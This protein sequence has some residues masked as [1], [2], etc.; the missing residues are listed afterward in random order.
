[1]FF[2]STATQ[3]FKKLAALRDKNARN[4]DVLMQR[5]AYE[6]EA[7][8][9]NGIMALYYQYQIEQ[10]NADFFQ[11]KAG[12][13]SLN[14]STNALESLHALLECRNNETLAAILQEDKYD[15]LLKAFIN[16]PEKQESQYIIALMKQLFADERVISELSD[17]ANAS[18]RYGSLLVA[19]DVKGT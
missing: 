13:L 7:Y 1:M 2:D 19:T 15:A 8:S 18:N 9:V 16:S 3:A 6:A 11:F 14:E 4:Q 12:G 10:L 17:I 5:S